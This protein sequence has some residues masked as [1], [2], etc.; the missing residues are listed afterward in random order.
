MQLLDTWPRAVKHLVPTGD[1]AAAEGAGESL[2]GRWTEPHRHYHT[3]Q[4]L[5]EMLHAIDELSSGV[6]ISEREQQL[7]VVAAWLHDAVYDVKSPPGDSERESA[8]LARNLL[9]ALG[10]EQSDRVTVERL[11]LLTIEHD[12]QWDSRVADIFSDADLAILAATPE[13][14]DEYCGQVR[15]EYAHV[16][17]AAYNLARSAILRALVD[18]P[19]VYRSPY[20]REAWTG[21]ARANVRRELDRLR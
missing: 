10:F 15:A 19:E 4:H 9:S 2:L 20:A 5:T 7:A 8:D 1:S 13:R 3:S 14:F 12:A 6:G 11:I 17:E 18:R 16:P 21:R